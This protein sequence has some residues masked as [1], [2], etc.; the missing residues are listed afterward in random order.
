MRRSILDIA[1][2]EKDNVIVALGVEEPNH[3]LGLGAIP[4]V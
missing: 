4:R 2:I 3:V 1:V